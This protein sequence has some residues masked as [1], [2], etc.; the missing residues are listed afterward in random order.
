[1]EASFRECTWNS[2][3]LHP[4]IYECLLISQTNLTISS[5][6][7]E[8]ISNRLTSSSGQ[9]LLPGDHCGCMFTDVRGLVLASEGLTKVRSTT[10]KGI[11]FI[12]A[13]HLL[14]FLPQAMDLLPLIGKSIRPGFETLRSSTHHR[15]I[16]LREGS[17]RLTSPSG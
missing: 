14:E 8:Q 11:D 4:H 13:A 12:L 9:R 6:W 3:L 10:N 1:M 5:F 7:K 2:V 15:I 17:G 16:K